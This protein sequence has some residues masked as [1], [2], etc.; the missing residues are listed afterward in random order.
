MTDG[1]KK[2]PNYGE[3]LKAV[4]ESG[5]V[6]SGR[7]EY[8]DSWEV[9]LTEEEKEKVERLNDLMLS[10]L[11][12]DDEDDDEDGNEDDETNLGELVVT[13]GEEPY[14]VNPV[15]VEFTISG[16]TDNQQDSTE[17]PERYGYFAG[18]YDGDN[19]DEWGE[20]DGPS[21][22]HFCLVCGYTDRI[23]T[24]HSKT[25]HWC[26]GECDGFARFKRIDDGD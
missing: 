22:T 3:I 16:D 19:D 8:S 15:E 10:M 4:R 23:D 18:A 17:R 11:G 13:G 25:E 6:V 2:K 24:P 1:D 7:Y 9:G 26:A 21:D 5:G 14:E 12:L 20:D